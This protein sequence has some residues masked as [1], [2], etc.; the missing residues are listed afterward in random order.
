MLAWLC[1]TWIW[2]SVEHCLCKFDKP[3][4]VG[5]CE[6]YGILGYGWSLLVFLIPWGNHAQLGGG[7]VA[8]RLMSTLAYGWLEHCSDVAGWVTRSSQ[9]K[10]FVYVNLCNCISCTVIAWWNVMNMLLCW[11]DALFF[12]IIAIIGIYVCFLQCIV[13]LSCRVRIPDWC[14]P[15]WPSLFKDF[16]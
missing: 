2:I 5:L 16:H 13:K 10:F 3:N 7:S 15:G 9:D 11:I 12:C 14:W 6:F 4:Y 1:L 8:K